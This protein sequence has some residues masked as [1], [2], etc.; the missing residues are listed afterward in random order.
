MTRSTVVTIKVEGHIRD[1]LSIEVLDV[2][3]GLIDE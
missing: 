1:G 3:A 2:H